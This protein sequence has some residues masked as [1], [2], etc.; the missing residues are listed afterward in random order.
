MTFEMVVGLNVYSDKV[1]NLYRASISPLL[2]KYEGGFRYDFKINETLIAEESKEINR[3]FLIFFKNKDLM[4]SFF[5]DSEYLKIKEE[6]FTNAV[7]STTIIS[8]YERS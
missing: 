2:A 4:N 8:E 5:S 3:L 1:Y 7:S 6:F